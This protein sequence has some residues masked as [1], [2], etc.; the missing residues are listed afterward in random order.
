MPAVRNVIGF[1]VVDDVG[2]VG[3]GSST[4]D[5]VGARL[6]PSSR[7]AASGSRQLRT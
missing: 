7:R 1:E 5:T 2:D 6:R 4:S 3:V